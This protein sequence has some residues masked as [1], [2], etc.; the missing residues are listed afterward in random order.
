MRT[1]RL[2]LIIGV[3][4][5]AFIL[6]TQACWDRHSLTAPTAASGRVSGSTTVTALAVASV[7]VSPSTASVTI[8]GTK[9]LTAVA[10]DASGNTLSGLTL[11]WTSSNPAVATVSS[12][13]LVKGVALGSA[14]VTAATG[15]KSGSAAIAVVP[16]VLVGAGDIATCY[17]IGDEGTAALLDK[18]A[19][20]VITVGDNAYPD[21]TALNYTLCYAPSWGRHKL[22][23]RPSP[24]NHE[25]HQLGAV[26]YFDYFGAAAGARGKGYYSYDLGSW[27]V[28]ALNSNIDASSTS[29]QVAWL[30]ADLAAH[31]AKC[32][33]A[34]WHHPRFSS[35]LHGNS[36]KMQPVWQAL[37]NAGADVV[38]S[39]HDHLYERFAPQTPTGGAD[40]TRGI[41]EFVVGTGGASLRSFSTPKPNSQFRYN[42]S[43]GVLKLELGATSYRWSFIAVGGTVKDS[44]SGSCH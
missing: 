10:R 19:G 28:V 15:G 18:I 34:Y 31:P 3:A 26:A 21:G 11:T 25:Y 39:A 22:R 12:T 38:V 20:T 33:L 27:H 35:G 24:G 40:A 2:A 13:G 8:E 37:Y 4:L 29:A 43:H 30:K 16:A 41:R 6:L 36:T 14:T 32:T 7:T 23:T 9:Q 42:G 17:S 44:G 5:A 1:T